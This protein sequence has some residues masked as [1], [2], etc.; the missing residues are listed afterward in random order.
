MFPKA[1]DNFFNPAVSWTNKYKDNDP[2][3]GAKFWG[4]TTV[5]VEVT[6]F[7]HLMDFVTDVPNY[8]S[9]SLPLCISHGRIKWYQIVSRALVATVVREAGF[10]LVYSVIYK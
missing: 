6:D 10:N 7:K 9:I 3:K 4:S 1:N 2:S 8:V 5:F